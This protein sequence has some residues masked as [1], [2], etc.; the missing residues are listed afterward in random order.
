MSNSKNGLILM[1]LI[2]GSMITK[3]IFDIW[4]MEQQEHEQ[5]LIEATTN[6]IVEDF[7]RNLRKLDDVTYEVDDITE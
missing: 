5:K 1:G 2:G 6:P 4:K 7:I 3:Y